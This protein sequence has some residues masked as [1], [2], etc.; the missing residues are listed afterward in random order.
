MHDE[1]LDGAD[2]QD[3][4]PDLSHIDNANFATPPDGQPPTMQMYLWHVPGAEPRAGPVPPDHRL[5]DEADVVYH[6][7]THGLSN[8][9]V[10]DADGNS[11]LDHPGRLDG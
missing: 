2:T 6:E 9:L 4:V 11:T 8:R 10:I 7:Y 5:G 3:G 1:S